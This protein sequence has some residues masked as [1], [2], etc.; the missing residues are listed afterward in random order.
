MVAPCVLFTSS[1]AVGIP[2]PHHVAA[3]FQFPLCVAV[4]VVANPNIGNK[5]I[6]A[7][8]IIV[9]SFDVDCCWIFSI[10]TR[11]QA[12][13][14]NRLIKNWGLYNFNEEWVKL[15]IIFLKALMD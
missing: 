15:F 3:S 10:F 13:L 14:I 9:L 11:Q 2:A 4:Y 6:V 1:V 8:R 12:F 5:L 7:I